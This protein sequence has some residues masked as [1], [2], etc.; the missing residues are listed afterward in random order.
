MLHL[1]LPILSQVV[2]VERLREEILAGTEY[3]FVQ[4]KTAIPSLFTPQQSKSREKLMWELLFWVNIQIQT[5][6]RTVPP[7]TSLPLGCYALFSYTCN[8]YNNISVQ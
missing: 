4:P 6:T 2:E 1:I 7:K 8:D 5:P 3:G